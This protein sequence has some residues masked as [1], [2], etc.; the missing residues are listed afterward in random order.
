VVAIEP[1]FDPALYPVGSPARIAA[2]LHLDLAVVC[3]EARHLLGHAPDPQERL[4]DWLVP[5]VVNGCRA[6]LAR[7]D[8]WEGFLADDTDEV[9]DAYG[10]IADREKAGGSP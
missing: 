6:F 7:D 4:A 9:L 5:R 3:A 2:V 8:G 10:K 1:G